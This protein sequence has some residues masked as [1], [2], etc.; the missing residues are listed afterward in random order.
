MDLY[1]TRHSYFYSSILGLISSKEFDRS[2][3]SDVVE[4]FANPYNFSI[5]PNVFPNGIQINRAKIK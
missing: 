2:V 1:R 4:L 5:F 3:V